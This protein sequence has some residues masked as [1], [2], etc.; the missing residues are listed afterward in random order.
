MNTTPRIIATM[1]ALVL[2]IAACGDDDSP[3]VGGDNSRLVGDL[4]AVIAAENQ[5]SSD[6]PMSDDQA[7]CFATALID[8]LGA[9]RMAGALDQ[10]FEEFMSTASQTER[11][12]VVDAMFDCADFGAAMTA[13]FSSDISPDSAQC[14]GEAFTASDD[15][16]DAV[17]ESFTAAGNAAFDDPSVMAALLPAMLECLSADELIQLGDS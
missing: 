3:G 17:A 14:L 15:F 11:R 5:S 8:V 16:R 7:A 6:F 2:V 9:E 1:L 13:E 10:E 12:A 4:T